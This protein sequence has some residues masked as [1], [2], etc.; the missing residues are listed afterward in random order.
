M[1]FVTNSMSEPVQST[2][3]ARTESPARRRILIAAGFAVGALV[4]LVANFLPTGPAVDVAHGISSLGLIMGSALFAAWFARRGYDIVAVGFALLALAQGV[5][6]SA[7]TPADP[8]AEATFAGGAALYAPALLLA[9]LP[10][11]LPA[12]ARI[13]GALAAVPFG[14]HG[15]LWWLGNAPDSSGPFA[16][17]GYML[18]TLAVV[19]W[20]VAVL[21]ATPSDR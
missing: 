12:W 3:P 17:A 19:G 6:V 11:A 20:I 15:L 8:G 21:R 5:I 18:L 4:G 1:T 7:G 9:S 16:S 2:S 14:A 13:V 10:A